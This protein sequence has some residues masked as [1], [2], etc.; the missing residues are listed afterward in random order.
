M[1]GFCGA[2]SA[3]Q[4]VSAVAVRVVDTSCVTLPPFAGHF[5]ARPTP[6][7]SY[8]DWAGCGDK[9]AMSERPEVVG[10]GLVP[11]VVCIHGVGQQLKGEDVLAE[12]WVPAL[13]SGM[14][15]TGADETSLPERG[16][17]G[18][19]FY[20]DTFRPAGRWLGVG[21]QLLTPDDIDEFERDLLSAWWQGASEVDPGVIAPGAA[22]LARVPGGVQRDLRALSGSAFFAGVAERALLRDLRQVRLYLSDPSIRMAV[23]ERVA[24]VI[25]EETRVLVGHSLGTV[26][27]Y[28]ALCAHPEWPVGM[29][30]TLGSPLGI[31]NLVF[32]RLRPAPQ[33]SS[34]VVTG[35]WPGGVTSWVNVADAGDVVALVKDLRPLFGD[36]VTCFE[37]SNGARAHAVVPYLTAREVGAAVTAG[38]IDLEASR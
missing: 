33:R 8:G 11:K 5:T 26:V 2:S 14:R 10:V 22:S 9:I 20:G 18:F 13:L 15:R 36:Q 17:V 24:A 4:G 7:C 29:L 28:E 3:D 16:D 27:A 37:I 30:V 32:D 19:A 31:Q 6:G 35:R 1:W 12:E 21:D 38:L 34:S 23:Q 25:D